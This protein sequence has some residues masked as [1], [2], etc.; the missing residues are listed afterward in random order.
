MER[1]P[2][3]SLN[4]RPARHSRPPPPASRHRP[5]AALLPL[6]PASRLPGPPAAPPCPACR[7][8]APSGSQGP[9]GDGRPACGAHAGARSLGFG[10]GLHSSPASEPANVAAAL[11]GVP[12]AA[13]APASAQAMSARCGAAHKR[14][15]SLVG[16]ANG[17]GAGGAAPGARGRGGGAGRAAVVF[18]LQPVRACVPAPAAYAACSAMLPCPPAP[19]R[20]TAAASRVLMRSVPLLPPALPPGR[21]R[22]PRP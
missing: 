12:V 22:S 6:L 16:A 4:S 9:L 14:C 1:A 17:G 7:R 19:G 15:V 21:S 2:A 18:D 3:A 8:C 20:C 10:W 11:A 5:A 13:C